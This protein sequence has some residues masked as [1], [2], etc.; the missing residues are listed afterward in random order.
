MI[1]VTP[2]KAANKALTWSSENP[3]VA[4]ASSEGLVTIQASG[5]AV[6]T[7]TTVDSTK[8]AVCTVTL[9]SDVVDVSSPLSS[10]IESELQP[11]IE[12]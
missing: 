7:V 11:P 8:T 1:I 3:T 10:T 5:S 4:G 6:V 12:M 2:E 9:T